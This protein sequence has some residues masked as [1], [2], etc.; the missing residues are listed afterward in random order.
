MELDEESFP[1][2]AELPD[3]GPVEGVDFGGALKSTRQILR[4]AALLSREAVS[5]HPRWTALPRTCNG[6]DL[7]VTTTS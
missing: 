1:L 4:L 6:S 7:N 5:V 3:P 2:E